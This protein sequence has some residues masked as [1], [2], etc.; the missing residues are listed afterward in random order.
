MTPEIML[1]FIIFEDYFEIEDFSNFIGIKPTNFWFK[2]DISPTYKIARKN[3]HWEYSSGYIKTY[4]LEK[5]SK[6]FV[7]QFKPLTKKI[8]EYTSKN[9]LNVKICVV[10]KFDHD[11]KPIFHFSKEFLKL[12]AKL[13]AVIDMDL[14]CFMDGY[15]GENEGVYDEIVT[16][17]I[18]LEFS[19]SGDYF[20]M[21]H[22]GNLIQVKPT[23]FWFKG[24]D[25]PKKEETYWKYSYDYI[26]THDSRELSAKFFKQFAPLAK[27]ISEYA[28][29]NNLNIKINIIAECF[30]S[31]T[32]A[33]IFNKRFLKL[34]VKLNAEIDVNLYCLTEL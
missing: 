15:E 10:A 26:R 34:L 8:Y 17:K 25:N 16:P 4:Y 13:N 30:Y 12:L 29:E 14:Y 33:I 21:E 24:D 1:E 23:N 7:E 18:K 19:I 20:D 31:Q 11:K 9:R 27:K 2:G 5:L 22:F 6:R 3:T 32:P 28:I